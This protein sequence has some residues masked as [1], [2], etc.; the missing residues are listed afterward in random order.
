MKTVKRGGWERR[1]VAAEVGGRGGAAFLSGGRTIR[2]GAAGLLSLALSLPPPEPLL[3]LGHWVYLPET[4]LFFLKEKWKELQRILQIRNL[5]YRKS[6]L[7]GK[8]KILWHIF[9]V[10]KKDMLLGKISLDKT[11]FSN[12]LP[13]PAPIILCGREIST[14]RCS[15]W[16]QF[17]LLLV[18]C[19]N[20]SD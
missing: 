12:G 18:F 11:R 13:S 8:F 1:R 15:A 7:L 3:T 4:C 14:R 20:R 9:T 16:L 10:K 17:Q 2:K 5:P 6:F 19:R